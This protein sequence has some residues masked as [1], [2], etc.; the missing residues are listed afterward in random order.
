VSGV[1]ALFRTFPHRTFST[2]SK[3]TRRFG[4]YPTLARVAAWGG[5]LPIKVNGEVVGAIGLAGA[6]VQND[7]RLREGSPSARTRCGAD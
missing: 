5:G 4:W 1:P 2:L 7:V 3:A 6:T